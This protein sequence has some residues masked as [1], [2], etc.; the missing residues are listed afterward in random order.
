MSWPDDIIDAFSP[1]RKVG[2]YW[3]CRCPAHEDRSP[4]LSV[5]IGKRD[6]KAILVKCFAGCQCQDIVAK[7]GLRMRDLFQGED[8]PLVARKIVRVYRYKDEKG[9]TLY[10]KVRYEPKDFRQRRWVGGCY[11]WGLGDVRRVPYM[12]EKWHGRAGETVFICAGEKDAETAA[13]LGLTATTTTEGEGQ[14][15]GDGMYCRFFDGMRVVIVP[16]NDATGR[17]HAAQVAGALL[18][19]GKQES[20][21]ILEL[22]HM[23]GHVKDLTDWAEYIEREKGRAILLDMAAALPRW[24]RG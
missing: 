19:W 1:V 23:G 18:M 5:W 12:L 13:S 16:D 21:S 2:P 8:R 14:G 10:E 22:P 9:V 11:E 4:S 20:I 17:R 15:W 3:Q 6:G 7:A 24:A